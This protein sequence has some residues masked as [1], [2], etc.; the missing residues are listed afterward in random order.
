[1]KINLHIRPSDLTGRIRRLWE[2]AGPKIRSIEAC[3]DAA[4]GSPVFTVR[5]RYTVRGWTE[6][7]QGFQAGAALLQF[8]ATGEEKFLELGGGRRF[9]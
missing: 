2:L 6:W 1:M 4:K 8:D 5:G 7:T 9:A 3:R